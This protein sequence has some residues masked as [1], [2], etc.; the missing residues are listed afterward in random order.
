MP[1]RTRDRMSD[2]M[3]D[4]VSE[5]VSDRTSELVWINITGFRRGNQFRDEGNV[6]LSQEFVQTRGRWN[7]IQI[8]N[9]WGLV[10]CGEIAVSSLNQ[11]ISIVA[12]QI[13]WWGWWFGFL[14]AMFKV[15]VD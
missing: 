12:Y 9:M 11:Q 6:G 13:N 3:P 1:E 2:A 10:N 8:P 7:K 5:Y 14:A 15:Y 4:I